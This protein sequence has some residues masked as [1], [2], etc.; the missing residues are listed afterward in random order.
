[1]PRLDQQIV[2]EFEPELWEGEHL[3]W[4]SQS[5]PWRYGIETYRNV[6]LTGFIF[7]IFFCCL[8]FFLIYPNSNF[9]FLFII[10]QCAL[11]TLIPIF[12]IIEA[13]KIYYGVTNKRIIILK[14][15]LKTKMK[16]Y[17]DDYLNEPH[18]TIRNDGSGDIIFGT[19]S[20]FFK[21][22]LSTQKHM[23]YRLNGDHFI[24]KINFGDF[25]WGNT[26]N[27]FVRKLNHGALESPSKR[28]G[29]FGILDVEMVSKLILN[30]F[31]DRLVPNS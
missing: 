22:F 11:T 4:C 16:F 19:E 24:R 25:S 14:K 27:N 1:M 28:V 13:R 12:G 17:G 30:T 18:S 31:K 21:Y 5:L 7:L 10:G 20:N 26:R 3:L 23:T 9:L 6:S 8:Y 15:W 2:S 29:L